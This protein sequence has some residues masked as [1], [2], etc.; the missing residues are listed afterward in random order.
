MMMKPPSRRKDHSISTRLSPY[1]QV[2]GELKLPSGVDAHLILNDWLSEVFTPLHLHSS[3]LNKLW[4]SAEDAA[5]RAMQTEP[6]LQDQQILL[7]IYIPVYRPSSGQTWGFFRIEK[8]K[9]VVENK[10]FL[11]HLIEFYL[12]MERP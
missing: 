6:I 2:L 9:R 10:K 4:K 3:F 12:Y 1:W 5:M 7:R 8:G 11:D